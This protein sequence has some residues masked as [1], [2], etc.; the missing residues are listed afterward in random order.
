MLLYSL[1]FTVVYRMAV[2]VFIIIILTN[3]NQTIFIGTGKV[4]IWHT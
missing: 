2:Y 1:L 3:I 4:K